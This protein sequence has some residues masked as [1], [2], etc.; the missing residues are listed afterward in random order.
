[1]KF[2]AAILG[3]VNTLL[4]LLLAF[5]IEITQDQSTAIVAFVNALI[6]VAAF[7]YDYLHPTKI[8]PKAG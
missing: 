3:L 8:V 6:V 4:A 7:G 2:T 1:M 5:G